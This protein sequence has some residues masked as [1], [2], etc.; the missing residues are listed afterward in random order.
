MPFVITRLCR[1]CVDG[2]CVD[3]C[4]T[5]CIVAHRPDGRESELPNQLFID[6]NECID[7]RLCEPECPWEAIHLDEEVPAEFAADIE[8]N[9]RSARRSDG[10]AVPESRLVRRPS[11]EEVD[12]NKAR[13]SAAEPGE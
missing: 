6:P 2:S 8:L 9:A 3:V 5:D 1:D 13:W 11:Q 7:C 12:R 4:P 10:Y